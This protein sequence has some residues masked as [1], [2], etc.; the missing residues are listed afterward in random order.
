VQHIIGCTQLQHLELDTGTCDIKA[1]LVVSIL[2]SCKQLTSL[3]LNYIIRQSELDALLT[4]PPQLTSFTCRRL[5]LCKDRSAAPC[6][7]KELVMT[8]QHF[9]AE[10]LAC[11]PTG[12]LTRLAF[13]GNAVFPSPF[14]TLEITSYGVSNTQEVVR[15]S[16]VNLMRCPAWQQCGPRVHVSLLWWL[17]DSLPQLLSLIP[18]LALLA[19]KEVKLSI[20]YSE[21]ALGASAVQQLGATLGNSLKHLV[22]EECLLSDDFWLAVRA[23]LPGLQQLTIGDTAHK[24]PN[25]FW[26]VAWARLQQLAVR[27]NVYCA[28]DVQELASFCSHATRPLQLSL[29]QRL[30]KQVEGKLD[31]EG[32][33]MGA[34]QVTV[35]KAIYV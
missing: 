32:R 24:L 8:N 21:A 31:Q 18:A 17:G 19:S 33:W 22:L 20:D 9:R 26:S 15:R 30:Y 6:S 23:H 13:Q 7:W 4:L 14:P 28:I 1:E 3:A 5:H 10:T 12:S 16:L 2:T 34:P 29:G 25:T 27:G 35:I 11:L